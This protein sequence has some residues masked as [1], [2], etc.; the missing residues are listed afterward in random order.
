MDSLEAR[1]PKSSAEWEA[2]YELRWRIL[3]APWQQGGC[4]RDE[5]D[6]TSTHRMACRSDGKVL[7]VGR[8]HR[9]DENSGQIRYMAV[10]NGF[11]RRGIGTLILG[12]LEQAA[13][14]MGIEKMILHARERAVPFYQRRGYTTVESS[15]LLFGEIQHY[16]M[17]KKLKTVRQQFP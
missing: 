7:A 4:D 3:R 8:L 9:L 16:L 1:A 15:F 12:A 13:I 5:T 2:Y 14:D 6:S 10:E 17:T 11:E